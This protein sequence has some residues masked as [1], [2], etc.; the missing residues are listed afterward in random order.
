MRVLEK[1]CGACK[2]VSRMSCAKSSPHPSPCSQSIYEVC[3]AKA[4]LLVEGIV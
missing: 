1:Y 4:L 3:Y 2:K